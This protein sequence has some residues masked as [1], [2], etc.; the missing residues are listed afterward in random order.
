MIDNKLFRD[1]PVKSFNV[2]VHLGTPWIGVIVDDVQRNTGFVEVFGEL[3]PVIGL[4]LDDLKW[5]GL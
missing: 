1:C 4:Y 2:R 3:T 5:N